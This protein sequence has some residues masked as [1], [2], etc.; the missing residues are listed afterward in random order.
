[1]KALGN[2]RV[3]RAPLEVPPSNPRWTR[4]DLRSLKSEA[5][6]RA[7]GGK[8]HAATGTVALPMLS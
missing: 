7:S 1:M 6:P 8:P 4:I 3:S 2:A 5:R